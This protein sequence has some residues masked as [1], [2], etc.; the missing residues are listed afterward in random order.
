MSL[1]DDIKARL[2]ASERGEVMARNTVNEDLRILLSQLSSITV[3]RDYYIN[4]YRNIELANAEM[5]R[6]DHVSFG[7]ILAA[8]NDA[9]EEAA[10]VRDLFDKEQDI[11]ARKAELCDKAVNL[12]NV[13]AERAEKKWEYATEMYQRALGNREIEVNKLDMEKQAL[14]EHADKLAEASQRYVDS[15]GCDHGAEDALYKALMIYAAYSKYKEN[16]T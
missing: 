16:N 12:A 13:R 5:T 9:M 7:S 8:R 1:L 11:N 14:Q 10:R 2:R 15:S 6:N 3:D 4:K